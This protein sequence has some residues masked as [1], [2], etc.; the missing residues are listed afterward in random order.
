MTPAIITR[1][2]LLA[3]TDLT[4]NMVNEFPELQGTMGY[5]YA[6]HDGEAEPVALASKEH[7]LPRF[8]GDDL[9]AHPIS[10]IIALADRIDTLVGTF[11]IKQI[12]T[13][14]KDPFG[15]R[16][17]ALGILRILLEKN[18]DLDLQEILTAALANFSLPLENTETVAQVLAFIQERQ[19]AWYQDQGIP[20]DVFAAVAA[21]GINNPLDMQHRIQ[22]VQTFKKLAEA[23]SLSVANKRV[24]NILSKYT[25]ALQATS[26]NPALFDNTAEQ[27]LARQLDEKDSIVI[28][29]YQAKKYNDVLLR[30]AELR[31]PIDDF[32]DQVMV[33]VDD[34]AR[35]E[36]RILLLGKLRALFLQ[37]ADI[38]LL[39]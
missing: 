18:I 14:D 30:L 22:A 16:R 34:K 15:L 4:T 29:L 19:R 17:A 27:E 26:I 12:P 36:N 24:S 11:G 38:A 28:K 35:R 7:Y 21:L 31:K 32:F 13:G 5:Y 39:Q 23:E 6:L 20:A 2:A 9:P 10:Q 37:V 25:D 1:A 3:K 8:A 33:M